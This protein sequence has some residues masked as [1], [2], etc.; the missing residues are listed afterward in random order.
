MSFDKIYII[1]LEQNIQRKGVLIYEQLKSNPFFKDRPFEIISAVDGRKVDQ[2]FMSE[3]G[4][5]LY[6]NWAINSDNVW[7]NRP[8][9][10]GEI[11]CALSHWSV[12]NKAKKEGHSKVLILEEDFLLK[13]LDY[14]IINQ[15]T[16]EWE[17]FFLGRVPQAKDIAILP[18]G[19]VVPG[20]SYQTHAYMLTSSGIDI[21][22]SSG[23]ESAIIPVDEFLSALYCCHPRTDIA[24]LYFTKLKALALDN[25]LIEQ[26]LEVSTTENIM[27]HNNVDY[28]PLHPQLYD[29]FGASVTNWV[30][31]YVNIQLVE[32]E[33]DLICEEPIVNVFTFPVFT[34]IFCSELIEEAEHFGQWE[35]TRHKRYPT[36]DM[37][38]SAFG[39]DLIYNF[40]VK[41]YVMPL[42]LY[43]YKLED[44]W[45][46]IATENFIARYSSDTQQ[47]LGIHHDGTYLSLI[48]TLNTNFK[49]GGTYFPKFEKLLKPDYPGFMS[50]HPG[51][52][53]YLH[54][55]RPV[56][57]GKRYIVAS[58]LS[59]D[60]YRPLKARD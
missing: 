4:F 3:N 36:N 25:N 13:D 10:P 55:A 16:Y 2:S 48:L 15:T 58:F 23:F 14:S 50:V 59:E 11:G 6:S 20:F 24:G 46:N 44:Y 52:V 30:N 60:T 39:I 51:M 37:L 17:I 19:L 43:K 38:L 7:W 28:V 56:I 32:G 1:C 29:A 53:G 40:V 54:G 45:M 5:R 8:L 9:K 33:F 41:K 47:H 42:I 27:Q 49:G 35:T 31:R 12:W 57:E 22:L 18:L 21:L 26:D 34:P